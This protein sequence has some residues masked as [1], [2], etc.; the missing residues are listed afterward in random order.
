MIVEAGWDLTVKWTTAHT[1]RAE[2]AKMTAEKK[3]IALGMLL[4]AKRGTEACF[5]F[6]QT[7]LRE[8]H[9]K[10]ERGFMLRLSVQ[11][12][13]HEETVDYE[14]VK[15]IQEEAMTKVR[16]V[17]LE[18]REKSYDTHDVQVLPRRQD[19]CAGCGKRSMHDKAQGGRHGHM[20]VAEKETAVRQLR[21]ETGGVV[22]ICTGNWS[23]KALFFQ[24]VATVLGI[25]LRVCA[26]RS[27][28]AGRS[29]DPV[30]T[31]EGSTKTQFRV[32]SQ[33]CIKL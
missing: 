21:W 29:S 10:P 8:T 32:T 7:E 2:T 9:M 24:G 13:P 23:R 4:L 19:M 3:Q 1:T 31:R 25:R 11:V 18:E 33:E 27:G 22:M 28:H 14:D 12:C 6:F 16:K 15:Q 5:F 30:S 20:W 17:F 26:K